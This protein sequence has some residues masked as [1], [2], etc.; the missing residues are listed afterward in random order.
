MLAERNEPLHIVEKNQG[1]MS[2]ECSH[3]PHLERD[4]QSSGAYYEGSHVSW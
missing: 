1:N 3:V 2:A 4:S